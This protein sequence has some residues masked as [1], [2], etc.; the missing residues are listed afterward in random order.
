MI[1]SEYV[2]KSITLSADINTFFSSHP[3]AFLSSH[4]YLVNFSRYKVVLDNKYLTR[5]IVALH[6]KSLIKSISSQLHSWQRIISLFKVNID[7]KTE[8]CITI[9]HLSMDAM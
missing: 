1:L 5:Y 9:N 6:E 7:N 3:T 8:L 4:M 2:S